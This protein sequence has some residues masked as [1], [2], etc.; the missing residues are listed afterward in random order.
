MKTS[1]LRISAYIRV[2]GFWVPEVL[3]L[4]YEGFSKIRG[5]ILGV[6]S[7][8]YSILGSIFGFPH[9]GKLPYHVVMVN[10]QV[11]QEQDFSKHKKGIKT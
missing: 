1:L 10:C 2:Q 11:L 9:F 7:R 4:T 6:I 3:P 5:T 8:D